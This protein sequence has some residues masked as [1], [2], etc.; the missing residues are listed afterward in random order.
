MRYVI[1]NTL[2]TTCLKQEIL[3]EKIKEKDP[4]K[5]LKLLDATSIKNVSEF[6]DSL[7]D[8]D[9]IVISGGDGTLNHLINCYDFSNFKK[10]IYLYKA[11]NGNDFLRDINDLKEDFV[12]LN[13]YLKNLPTVTI[14]R[15]TYKFINGV[16]FGIDGQ[17]CVVSDQMKKDG[18]TD[19]NYTN[20]SIKLLLTSFKRVNATVEVDGKTLNFKNV[21]LASTMNGRYYGGGMM[22]AP[23]QKRESDKVTV[24]VWHDLSKL[25]ALMMFPKIFKGEHV[26][27][28]KKVDIIEGKN[29]KIT[30]DKPTGLQIDGESFADILTYS[31]SK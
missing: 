14:N 17:V 8:E 12:L 5:E 1:F 2:S 21:W 4:S 19:I 26:K 28:K 9:D 15:K 3:E 11:G 16:G 29:V 6:L 25:P 24:C 30:F 10:N 22:V 27:N 7:A 31:V 18:K 13:S 20:L 23:N